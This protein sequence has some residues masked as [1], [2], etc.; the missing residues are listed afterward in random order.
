MQA[1][2]QGGNLQI[3]RWQGHSARAQAV[4][5]AQ[6]LVQLHQQ[7][8]LTLLLLL[9]LLLL[10]H[11]NNIAA[12]RSFLLCYHKAGIWIY[13]LSTAASAAASA[14]TATRLLVDFCQLPFNEVVVDLAEIRRLLLPGQQVESN[15]ITHGYTTTAGCSRGSWLDQSGRGT[16]GGLN[17]IGSRLAD[18][19]ATDASL[20]TTAITAATTTE[21][22]RIP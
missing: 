4:E 12:S 20:G 10:L 21:H 17:L 13:V 18:T 7:L 19:G 11:C 5:F 6:L 22:T 2:G 1:A 15:Q 14:N 16:A 3:R 9:L 8:L